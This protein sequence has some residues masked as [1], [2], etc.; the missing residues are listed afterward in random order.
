VLRPP[1]AIDGRHHSR[2]GQVDRFS[3]VFTKAKDLAVFGE[4]QEDAS[5][6]DEDKA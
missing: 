6:D 5:E 2:V 1:K 3:L 4:G